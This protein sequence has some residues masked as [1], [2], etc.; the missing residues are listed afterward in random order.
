MAGNEV[1][2][3]WKNGKLR[4]MTASSAGN[5]APGYQGRRARS[6]SRV[7]RRGADIEKRG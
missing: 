5:A 1:V 2:L 4:A 7:L 6:E 3:F